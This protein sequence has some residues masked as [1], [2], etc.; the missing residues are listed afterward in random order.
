LSPKKNKGWAYFPTWDLMNLEIYNRTRATFCPH[1]FLYQMQFHKDFLVT[2][3]GD[4]KV[5]L[6][7]MK[8]AEKNPRKDS[9]QGRP[10]HQESANLAQ[11]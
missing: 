7:D 6:G 8:E 1:V 9:S 5:N 4:C 11:L 10:D 2:W 3:R